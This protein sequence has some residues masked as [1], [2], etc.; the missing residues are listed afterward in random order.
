MSNQYRVAPRAIGY[1]AVVTG[2]TAATTSAAFSAQT[3]YIR[4]GATGG[5]VTDRVNY[6]I[7]QTGVSTVATAYSTLPSGNVEF[8]GVSPGQQAV[9]QPSAAAVVVTITELE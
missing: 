3:R 4:L 5:A 9:V 2:T 6:I 1:Q 7:S 8:V